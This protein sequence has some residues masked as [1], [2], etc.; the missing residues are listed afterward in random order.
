MTVETLYGPVVVPKAPERIVVLDFGFADALLALGL[1]PTVVSLGAKFPDEVPWLDGVLDPKSIDESMMTQ[2]TVNV[3]AVAAAKPDLILG[4]WFAV[5]EATFQLLD[6]IAPTV[7][8][9]TAGNAGWEERLELTAEAVGRT[10]AVDSVRQSVLDAYAGL[11]AQVPQLVGKTYEYTGF[12]LDHGGFFW[13]NGSWLDPIGLVPADDQDNSQTAPA[14]SFENL[15]QLD[16]D[17]WAIFPPTPEDRQTLEGDARFA[18]QPAPANDLVIWL[19]WALANAT[20]NAGPLSLAWTV[21]QIAPT[22]IAGAKNL[23]E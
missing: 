14:V 9:R 21:D 17:V 8:A 5:D 12:G 16:A 2:R 7:S 10:A 18:Q 19:D 3:E 6:A 23:K 11:T 20:N 15:D 4:G 1:Q 22:L 13:G